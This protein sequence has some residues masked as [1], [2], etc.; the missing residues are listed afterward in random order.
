M[1]GNRN[2]MVAAR[3]LPRH[4]RADGS[5]TRLYTEAGAT[6]RIR[7]L[8]RALAYRPPPTIISPENEMDT[9][10]INSDPDPGFFAHFSRNLRELPGEL[11]EELHLAGAMLRN[12][13]RRWSKARLDYVVMP[14]G[15]ELPERDGPPRGF[16]ERRL[17]LGPVPF[18]MQQ[19]NAR[20]AAVADA[21]NVRGVVFIFRGFSARL[22]TLQNFRRAVERLRAAG[23]EVVVYT[24]YLSLGNY[25]AATAADRIIIPPTTFLEVLGLYSEVTFFKD[26]LSRVGVEADVVQISPYKTAMDQFGRSDMSPEQREQ[27]DWLLD[28]Q[29]AIVTE[30]IAAGRGKTVEEVRE[31]IDRGPMN[32]QEALA[33]GLVDAVAYDD[34]LAYLLAPPSEKQTAEERTDE[35]R[36]EGD[37]KTERPKAKLATWRQASRV[38]IE[39]PRQ[40]ER[41]AIG[42]VSLQG[43]IA[44]GPSRTPPIDLPIPFLG[45]EVAGEQTLVSALRQV[46]RMDDL[47]ALIFHVDSGGGSALAS[48]LIGRQLE[49][50][51]RKMPVLVYMGNVAASGGYYVAAPARHIMSQTATITGSIGVIMAHV[52]TSE[53]YQHL[54]VNRVALKRGEHA[55]LYG[56]PEP[57]TADERAIFERTVMEIYGQFKQVVAAG[58]QLPYDELD[59]VC[60]G[61]VWTGRQALAHGLVDSH[62]DFMDAIA[63]AAELGGLPTDDIQRLG[64]VNI[65]PKGAGYVIPKAAGPGSILS[66]A[67]SWFAGERARELNGRPLLL[68]PFEVRYR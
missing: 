1:G 51:A 30:A 22:A 11:R 25:F 44:M 36:P 23:K 34:E 13:R 58:R 47:A 46:E 62:G 14:I 45:G 15:G 43:A 26:A 20:L 24:P 12:R 5:P 35:K 55:G 66:E 2:R 53:L 52:S 27:L 49:Q 48:D 64:V 41:K 19:L 40:M 8:S 54:S 67:V 17:P 32:A 61:R 63:R 38:L 16:I 50:V 9:Q 21:E 7:I 59:P 60:L 57:L 42:V 39:K 65:H 68:L 3:R 56:D 6:A 29:F 33:C 28:E 10:L 31:L 4:P 37:E 18:S